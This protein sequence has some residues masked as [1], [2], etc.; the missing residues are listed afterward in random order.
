MVGVVVTKKCPSLDGDGSLSPITLF[1]SEDE[2]VQNAKQQS[3]VDCPN[4][5]RGG[6]DKWK[7]V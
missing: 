3:V 7:E 1:V 5:E 4:N 6:A 2:R